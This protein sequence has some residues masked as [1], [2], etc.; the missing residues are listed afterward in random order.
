[1]FIRPLLRQ[2]SFF[3]LRECRDRRL[4]AP[5]DQACK[6]RGGGMDRVGGLLFQQVESHRLHTLAV[7]MRVLMF[8]LFWRFGHFITTGMARALRIRAGGPMGSCGRGG[9]GAVAKNGKAGAECQQ[10]E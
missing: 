5:L 9:T 3:G 4:L 7:A 6:R 2:F 10:Q 1:M 8:R